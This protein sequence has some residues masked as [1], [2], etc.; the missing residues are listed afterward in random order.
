MRS[1]RSARPGQARLGMTL[2]DMELEYITGTQSRSPAQTGARRRCMRGR[3]G[4]GLSHRKVDARLPG[5][6]Y[7]NSHGARPI[8][9]IITVIK[10]IR[11]SRFSI[12]NSLSL[13]RWGQRLCV[14]HTHFTKG[15]AR[16]S[17]RDRYRGTSLIRNTPPVGPYSSPMPRD[18]W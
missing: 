13:G 10:W 1:L 4:Q 14:S 11:T 8:Y 9:L 5:K 3:I 17:E 12:I 6:G 2:P 18:R 16:Q 7:S 15:A